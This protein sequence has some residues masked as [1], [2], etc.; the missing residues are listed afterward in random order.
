M[1]IRVKIDGA[2]TEV[3]PATTLLEAIRAGGGD[4]PT[5]CF[6]E[7]QEPFGACRVCMVGVAGAPGPVAS[8]TTNLLI[9]PSA[10]VNTSCPEYEVVAV[11]VRPVS[12]QPRRTPAIATTG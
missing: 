6:D 12:E 4:V 5:L 8:C 7:R 3:R 11:D 10:D 1:S 9:G 2:P